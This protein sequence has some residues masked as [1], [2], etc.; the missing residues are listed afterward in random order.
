MAPMI[1]WSGNNS[2]A[3]KPRTGGG[4]ETGRTGDGDDGD[5]DPLG[6][7]GDDDCDDKRRSSAR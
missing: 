7:D 3:R 6:G 2:T 5:T 4:G 1:M